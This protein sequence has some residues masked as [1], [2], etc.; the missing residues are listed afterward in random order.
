MMMLQTSIKTVLVKNPETAPSKL[1]SDINRV[2]TDNIKSLGEDKYITITVLASFPEG[3]FLFSG[4]HEDIMV[5]RNVKKT[6]ESVK[7]EGMWLGI[8]DDITS[9]MEDNELTL[10]KGDILLLY[11]DGITE[12]MDEGHNIFSKKRL[13]EILRNNGDK[14]PEFIKNIILGELN[15]GFRQKDDVTM[16]ILKRIE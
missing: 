3:R 11:T 6:V 7:T 12:A 10:E 4:L 13:A 1:L 9:F 15:S 16:I 14:S 8:K 2:L 5:F